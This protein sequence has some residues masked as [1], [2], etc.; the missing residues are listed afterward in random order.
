MLFVKETKYIFLKKKK[1]DTNVISL[2]FT[3][4]SNNYEF[5][6]YAEERRVP[7]YD[8]IR[9]SNGFISDDVYEILLESLGRDGILFDI[10]FKKEKEA[11]SIKYAFTFTIQLLDARY[12]PQGE[13][14]QYEKETECIL[15]E[16]KLTRMVVPIDKVNFSIK[17]LLWVY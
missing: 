3:S 11:F 13:S 10:I 2:T 1:E 17:I 9:E 16:S 4:L 15:E 14:K 7:V 6:L 12:N 8:F 5:I